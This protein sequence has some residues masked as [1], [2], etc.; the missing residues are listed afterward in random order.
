M[1]GK[2][3]KVFVRPAMMVCRHNAISI[4]IGSDQN[5]SDKKISSSER[6]LRLSKVRDVEMV[7]TC[8]VLVRKSKIHG[9]RGG[10]AE[11]RLRW[12]R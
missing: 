11:D 8:A 2:V 4:F 12:N 9:C 3:Y 1:K 7:W 6:Q 5:G 10:Y